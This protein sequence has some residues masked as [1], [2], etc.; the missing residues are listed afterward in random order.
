MRYSPTA[1]FALPVLALVVVACRADRVSPTVTEPPLINVLT[2]GQA[3]AVSA[4]GT[5]VPVVDNDRVECPKADY[6]SIQAAVTAADPGSTI[7]V[8]A[9]TYNEWVVIENKNDL[10][11]L[12]KGL[13]ELSVTGRLAFGS[14]EGATETPF[15]RTSPLRLLTTT[16]FR[17]P[18]Q[19]TT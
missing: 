16:V 9:G 11:L 19:R 12:A 2:P 6:T 1:H 14:E 5:K 17:W 3:P 10:R 4:A 18:A 13:P 15:G 7:L 8:C